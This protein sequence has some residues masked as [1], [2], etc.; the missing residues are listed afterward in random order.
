MSRARI[1][2]LLLGGALLLLL[3]RG[4]AHVRSAGP[5]ATPPTPHLGRSA[6]AA[7]TDPALLVPPRPPARGVDVEAIRL[8]IRDAGAAVYL[9]AMFSET[10]SVLRRWTDDDAT[11]LRV[12]YVLGGVPGWDPEDQ[13]IARA[14]FHGWEEVAPVRFV[15]VLDTADAQLIVR[16]IP[17]FAIDRTGQTD[18]TWDEQGRIHRAVIQLAL[19][20]SGG[21]ELAPDGLR[22]V[23][24]HEVGHALGLPHSDLAAD[25]MFPATRRPALT[26]RD[27]ATVQLLYRLPPVSLK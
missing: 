11:A 2:L 7:R 14:A 6:Q 13:A 5:V 19:A 27:I 18:L 3:G 23:A 1:L 24:L 20:D 16:W 21:R 10:D 8:A 26:P 17:R 22:A 12:A 9:P 4:A 15:E 25:L